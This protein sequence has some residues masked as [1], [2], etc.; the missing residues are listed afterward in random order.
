MQRE[1]RPMALHLK[2]APSKSFTDTDQQDVAERVRSIISEIRERGDAAVRQYAEKFDNWS[3]DSYRLSDD[4]IKVIMDGLDPQVITDINFVQAQVRRFAQAQRDSLIDIEVETLPGVFLGHK[5]VPVQAAGA[6]IPGGKYPLTASAH[7]T[8]ITAKVAGVPRVV[9][10][11]PPIRGEIPAATVAAM[12]LAGADEIYILGGVQA[13]AAMAVGTETLAPV[14]MIAGPGNAYV[15]E[16]KRQLFGEVGIDLFAG[17]T[18]VLIVADE[19]ADPF[20]TA[21]DLLSQ[22]EHGPDSPAVL[23][24]TSQSLAEEVLRLIETLIPTMPTRDYAGAAWRDWG[25]VIVAENMDEAYEIADSF[26]SE[27]V[28]IFTANP[29]K[30]LTRMHHYGALFLGENTCVSYGDKVIG[31]NHVLPT[32]GAARYTGGLWVGKYLRT[33]TYQEIVNS[34]SSAELGDVCGR[35]ARVELFEGHARSGDARVWRHA[36]KQFDWIDAAVSAPAAS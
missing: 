32:L 36:G 24:T 28:Q 33:V 22:A 34:E 7:M 18:E 35:A 23:V 31:T 16:A 30:A 15:A 1:R 2:S 25:Q 12:K 27:H 21:V 8:I 17:P 29:R 11:T 9:A 14:N 19:N 13:V 20:F 3:K 10:C 6:Y 5:H 26:A 4:E